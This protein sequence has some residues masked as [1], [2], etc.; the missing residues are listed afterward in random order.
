MGKKAMILHWFDASEATKIGVR[1]ADQF[2]P[3]QAPCAAGHRGQSA[4]RTH[5]DGL[6][7]ILQRA[8]LEVRSLRLNFYKK[9]KFANSF[10]WRLLENG[11]DQTLADEVTQRLVLHLSGSRSWSSPGA[12]A[13]ADLTNRPQPNDAK[14][15]LAQGNRSMASGAYSEA[16]AFYQ[17]LIGIA[18]RHV[19]GLN[20][21]GAALAKLGRYEEAEAYFFQAIKVEPDLPDAHSNMGSALQLK[22]QYAGAEQFLR[23]AIKLNPRHVDARINLGLT[24]SFVSRMGEARSHFEKALKYQSRSADA[25]SGLAFIAM[26]EGG[27]DQARSLLT[28]ALQVNPRLPRA[29]ALQAGIRKMSASDNAWLENAEE[30]ADSGIPPAEESEL[31]FAI[32]KYYDDTQDFKRAFENYKLANDVLRSIAKPYDREAYKEFVSRMIGTFTQEVVARVNSGASNSVKPVFV[33]GM[34]RSGTSLAEQIIASHPSA[35]GA[36][37]LGFWADAMNEDKARM[38]EGPLDESKGKRLAEAYLRVLEA[39]SGD[40][41]RVVDK[42]PVNSDYLGVIHSVF[43]G[44][45]II[46]MQRDPIDTCLSCY[47]Q[48]F[49]LSLNYA[50]DLSDLADH[51]REHRRLMTHWRAVLPPGTLLDLPYEELVADQEGCTRKILDFLGLEW[52]ERVRNFHETKREVA[53]ASFWQVRQKLYKNSLQRW[54]N[55][56]KYIGPLRQLKS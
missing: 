53:T 41:L 7:L 35:K 26:T 10:K 30:V 38:N 3:Q 20:N 15:L 29:L 12:D 16:I 21:L 19:V 55:Y 2:A 17:D 27:F 39:K 40:A 45:R 51:Y 28:R 1:L 31:R 56:A 24:L 50:M 9:A 4:P 13:K 32:G 22:G 14:H 33:V 43:P 47:F 54:R 18:P 42:A 8:D 23:R 44:A 34:P 52:D 25:L 48:K 5:G 6:Q 49:V 36:G 46:Y 37:E 11:I